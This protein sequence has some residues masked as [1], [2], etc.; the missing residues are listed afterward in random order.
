M[1]SNSGAAADS[2]PKPVHGRSEK[3]DIS[4]TFLRALAADPALLKYW[5]NQATQVYRRTV[6]GEPI[7]GIWP[8]YIA[9][10]ELAM[11]LHQELEDRGRRV[12]KAFRSDDAAQEIGHIDFYAIGEH[13][14]TD[15]LAIELG[16]T[17][18][19]PRGASKARRPR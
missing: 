12:P 16:D 3:K 4:T 17:C 1:R 14:V 15:A 6:L 7:P 9:R 2:S 13:F 8:K 11:A 5:N 18:R 10:T 19:A